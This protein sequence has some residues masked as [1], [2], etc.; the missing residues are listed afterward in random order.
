M[1]I[2]M[3]SLAA[4]MVGGTITVGAKDAGGIP[5]DLLAMA[6][7]I[8]LSDSSMRELVGGVLRSNGVQRTAGQTPMQVF[9]SLSP[10]RVAA[11]SS[12]VQKHSE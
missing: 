3:W 11:I 1:A 10:S 12:G 9:Q 7:G 4:V 2:C 8:D 6:A 5:F